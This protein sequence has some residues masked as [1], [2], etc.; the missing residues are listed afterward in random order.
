LGLRLGMGLGLGFGLGLPELLDLDL[1]DHLA[2]RLG[3]GRVEG[4]G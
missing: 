1:R 3:W 2:P 4:S